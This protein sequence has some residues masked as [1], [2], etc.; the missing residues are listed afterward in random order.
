M[1]Y[2]TISCVLCVLEVV[3]EYIKS[4][5]RLST[6][7]FECCVTQICDTIRTTD[8][9]N[10]M[11]KQNAATD[12]SKMKIT[13]RSDSVE[14]TDGSDV[15]SKAQGGMKRKQ[16]EKCKRKQQIRKE[17]FSHMC[18]TFAYGKKIQEKDSNKREKHEREATDR[19]QQERT[20]LEMEKTNALDVERQELA[21]EER[22]K[23]EREVEKMKNKLEKK[24]Q[25]SL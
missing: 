7:S 14:L 4:N 8:K 1:K 20:K 18:S 13:T 11:K 23:N 9:K 6:E 3:H 5:L 12:V 19:K 17:H 10:N 22:E 21:R 16:Q 15:G 25:E 24:H 2:Y